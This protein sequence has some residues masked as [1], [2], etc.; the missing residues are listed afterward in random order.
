MTAYLTA[1]IAKTR[2][3]Q[4][5]EQIALILSTELAYQKDVSRSTG[6]DTGEILADFWNGDS[7]LN[8]FLDRGVVLDEKEMPA[9]VVNCQTA[10]WEPGSVASKN[11]TGRYMVAVLTRS[12]ATDTA[13]G[14]A[15]AAV[16]AQR[17]GGMCR[18]ILMA[19]Q[20]K[21]LGYT[22]GTVV[23]GVQIGE[24]EIMTPRNEE[25]SGG[26]TAAILSV[27]VRYIDTEIVG[28]PVTLERLV[29][30]VGTD[31]RYKAVRVYSGAP[32]DPAEDLPEEP[33]PEEPEEP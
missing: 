19:Q 9:I 1:P 14:D 2:Q 12:A 5:K 25:N 33:E 3:E 26:V 15:L 24:M 4:I 17:I 18:A 27:E 31:G 6:D 21:T 29:S 30:F 22:P 7:E 28:A 10:Q 13:D 16:M 32:Y 23:G 11:A 20:Y 8:I